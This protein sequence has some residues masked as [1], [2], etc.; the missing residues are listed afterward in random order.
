MA[1]RPSL[2]S[3]AGGHLWMTMV[4]GGRVKKSGGGVGD[5][6]EHGALGD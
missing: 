2:A 1:D 6:G 3:P 4:Q 5:R